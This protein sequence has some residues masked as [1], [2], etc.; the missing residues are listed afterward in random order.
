MNQSREQRDSAS[1]SPFFFAASLYLFA[2]TTCERVSANEICH[3]HGSVTWAARLSISIALLFRSFHTVLTCSTCERECQRDM[4]HTWISHVSSETAHVYRPSF[5]QF[6]CIFWRAP[7]VSL[8]VPMRHVTHMNQ[9]CEQRDS[10]CLSRCFFAASMD[11]RHVSVCVNEAYVTHEYVMW[12]AR[13]LRLY[14]PV[15]PSSICIHMN[16]YVYICM[17]VYVYIYIHVHI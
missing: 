10:A 17:Y 11:F 14:R 8:W 1:L 4:S 3:T 2:W 16:I 9:S 12:V 13:L 5:S 6:P 15:S 7:P